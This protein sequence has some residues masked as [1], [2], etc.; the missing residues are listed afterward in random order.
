MNISNN[1]FLFPP[2]RIVNTN[3]EVEVV[4]KFPSMFPT[5][6]EAAASAKAEDDLL[7]ERMKALFFWPAMMSSI[8]YVPT[9]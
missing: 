1:L 8:K 7:F 6:E 4:E 3:G 5:E 2:L 9:Y